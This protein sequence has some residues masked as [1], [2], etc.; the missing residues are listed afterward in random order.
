MAAMTAASFTVVVT[1]RVRTG[2]RKMIRG[3]LTFGNGVDTYVV[4]GVPLPDKSKFG[5]LRTFDDIAINGVNGTLFDYEYRYN[6][7]LH[8]LQLFGD[9]ATAA[10]GQPLGEA[11]AGEAPTART[12]NFTAY[13][14]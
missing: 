13:G 7:P 10:A 8:R 1:S 12:V 4:A 6:K 5:F 11:G 2:K 3:T 14:W 9:R